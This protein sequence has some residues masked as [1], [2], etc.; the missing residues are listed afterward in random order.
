MQQEHILVWLPSPMGD[1][2]LA[3]PALRAL[4][5]HFQNAVITYYANRV[6][7][8]ALSPCHWNDHWLN[9]QRGWHA[10]RTIRRQGFTRVI[11]LKN[12]LGSA[13]ISC[14]A[15]IPRRIGY[16]RDHRA[17]LLTDKL[18]PLRKTEGAYLPL[19]MV[20]YYLQLTEHLGC[21]SGD[22]IPSLNIAAEDHD[23]LLRNHPQFREEKMS[24][25]ILVP[26]GA[27]GPSKCWPTSH[28]A[29]VASRLVRRYHAKVVLSVSP[30]EREKSIAAAIVQQ[31]PDPLV[32]LADDPMS[33]R[34]LKALF[35]RAD[36]IICNDTGPRH[37]GIAL[38]RRVISLFGPNDPAWTNTGYDGEIQIMA[39]GP[40]VR[41][42]KPTCRRPDVFCMETITVDT[43]F[44]AAQDL[45]G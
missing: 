33:L 36:L 20:D 10:I 31:C 38:R 26:G 45:L 25:V 23:S 34:E 21:E 6:V 4:R 27:F 16:A 7:R 30:D 32:N 13:A 37:I 18:H 35:S 2:I 12:S 5:N 9:Q 42:Q 11:L 43:V 8:E 24:L 1:A 29:Q 41:C 15:G 17:W 3:T 28:Y 44:R 22:K 14:L 19:S 39:P 40:C